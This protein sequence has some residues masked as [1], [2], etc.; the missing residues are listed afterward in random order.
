MTKESIE[1]IA[2][3]FIKKQDFISLEQDD[4]LFEAIM[5]GIELQKKINYDKRTISI[6][7]SI[8]I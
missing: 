1:E 8:G 6:S 7:G 5:F 4:K 2:E 3:K